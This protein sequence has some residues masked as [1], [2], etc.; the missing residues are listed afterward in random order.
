MAES[1]LAKVPRIIQILFDS[2][3]ID[4]DKQAQALNLIKEVQVV[5]GEAA[6]KAG[7]DAKDL[8]SALLWQSRQITDAA[9]ADMQTIIDGHTLDLPVWLGL[10]WQSADPRTIDKA[11]ITRTDAAIATANMAKTLV[12]MVNTI[13]PDLNVPIEERKI[14]PKHLNTD[15][16]VNFQR[17]GEA[18]QNL[19][20]VSRVLAGNNRMRLTPQQAQ[21]ML[22]NAARTLQSFTTIFGSRLSES[23]ANFC[24]AS[25]VTADEGL[26]L[27]E[28]TN[29]TRV[30]R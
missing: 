18:V 26:K 13:L 1:E 29:L 2:Q 19:C 17:L 12:I 22:Y 25:L 11:T 10:N 6:V 28:K 21:D 4:E 8:E 16:E 9:L 14:I 20:N 30:E 24:G 15:Q 3:K 27:V 5:S 23:A 7:A